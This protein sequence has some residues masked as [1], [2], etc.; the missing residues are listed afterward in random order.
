M[1]VHL[2]NR[3]KV[4]SDTCD[5]APREENRTTFFTKVSEVSNSEQTVQ[6]GDR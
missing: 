5:S 1:T 6:L 4:P 2:L 3:C